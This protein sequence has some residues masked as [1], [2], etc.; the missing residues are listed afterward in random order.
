MDAAGHNYKEIVKQLSPGTRVCCVVKADGYGHGAV[1]LAREYERLGADWF[2]VSNLE[3]A[4]QLR[5]GGLKLPIL[6]LGY[7]PPDMAR[8]ICR[9][10]I[11]QAVLSYDYGVALSMAAE[12]EGLTVRTH[13]KVDTGM[14]RIGFM[15]QDEERD[16]AALDE[17]EEICRLPGLVPEGIFTHFAVADEG[18][19]GREFTIRQFDIFCKAVEYLRERGVTFRI[20]HCA[21]SGAILDYPQMQLDM[22][23][24][25]I[26]LYG[27]NPSASVRNQLDLQPVMELKSVLSLVKTIPAHTTVSYGRKFTTN[28]ETVIGTVPVG[29]ADGYPRS[30]YRLASVLVR[31]KKARIIGR[32]CMDQLMVD[33]TRVPGAREGDEV[34]LFG[35]DAKAEI[36]VDQLAKYNHTIHYEIICGISKRVPRLYLREGRPVGRLDYICET[37]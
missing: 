7:T 8:Q 26:I 2:A 12:R 27:L 20:R 37:L 9:L 34:T 33:L 21:N 25:G 3:E 31:G 32:V 19:D 22:V 35:R 1:E 6:V 10:N 30:L 13:I 18:E 16:E 29:Y 36:T 23:R 15:Y 28:G 17:I 5:D 11:A 24:P 4:V 14:S